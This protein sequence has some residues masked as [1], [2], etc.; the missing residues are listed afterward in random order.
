ME[1]KHGAGCRKECCDPMRRL[2]M[3]NEMKQT[4]MH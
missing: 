4:R 2:Q 1:E 3:E